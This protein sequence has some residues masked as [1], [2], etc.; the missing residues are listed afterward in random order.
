ME[1]SKTHRV[2]GDD[3]LINSSLGTLNGSSGGIE[4]PAFGKKKNPSLALFK[5]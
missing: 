2:V 1:S 5:G 3:G 4:T